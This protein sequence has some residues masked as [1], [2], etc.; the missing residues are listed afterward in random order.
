MT[1]SDF[2]KLV[3][4]SFPCFSVR[5]RACSSGKFSDLVTIGASPVGMT[6]GSVAVVVVVT[7]SEFERF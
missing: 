3:S 4:S 2:F 7:F 5:R 1:R 6:G